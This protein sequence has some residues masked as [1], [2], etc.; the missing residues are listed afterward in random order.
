MPTVTPRPYQKDAVEEQPD[1][2]GWLNGIG[3]FYL[4]TSAIGAG[5]IWLT[6]GQLET[7]AGTGYS[8]V[9]I[10]YAI[11]A[12]LQGILV[13]TLLGAAAVLIEDVRS[14]RNSLARMEN[15]ARGVKTPVA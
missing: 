14:M 15:D 11:V 4:V 2:I 9:A 8:P 12:V 1:V 5:L 10:A 3:L 7:Q 6:F 13:R